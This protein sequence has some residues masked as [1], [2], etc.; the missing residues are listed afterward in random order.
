MDKPVLDK[1]EVIFF[2]GVPEKII[3]Q[4][5]SERYVKDWQAQKVTVPPMPMIEFG[6]H[7][8]R[9]IKARVLEWM[10]AHFGNVIT[11]KGKGGKP[12]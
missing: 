6:G 4:Y 11:H 5:T 10:E 12:A 3:E 9:F 2:L 1:Q 7:T 8:K